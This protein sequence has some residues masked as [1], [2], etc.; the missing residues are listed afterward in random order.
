VREGL[1]QIINVR[2]V[3]E[4]GASVVTQTD[5]AVLELPSSDSTEQDDDAYEEFEA[6]G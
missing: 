2:Y 6:T 5:Q 3:E 4:T 1:D